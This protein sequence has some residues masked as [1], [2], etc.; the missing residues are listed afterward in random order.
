MGVGKRSLA[1]VSSVQSHSLQSFCCQKFQKQL[2]GEDSPGLRR[3]RFPFFQ[4]TLSKSPETPCPHDKGSSPNENKCFHQSQTQQ[5]L[6]PG[7]ISRASPALQSDMKRADTKKPL[8]MR[9]TRA[10]GL[11]RD[12]FPLV[13][14]AES[15]FL[16][17]MFHGSGMSC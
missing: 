16:S 14:S 9:L 5:K 7:I 1:R 11:N 15:F 6:Y 13:S 3:L 17:E 8:V 10:T 2:K 4:S 12:C